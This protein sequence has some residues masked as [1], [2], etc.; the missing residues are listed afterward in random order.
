MK[1][2]RTMAVS[3]LA[4]LALFGESLSA[5]AEEANSQ[6]ASIEIETF[7]PPKPLDLI[8]PVYPKRDLRHGREGW[9]NC[10]LMIIDDPGT[11]FKLIELLQRPAIA[12]VNVL[13]RERS[14]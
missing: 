4:V 13:N 11:T 3:S 8:P 1:I 5:F 12:S 10:T 2:H 14:V 9:S 6:P 7:T